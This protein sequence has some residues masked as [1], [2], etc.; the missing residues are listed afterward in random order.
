MKGMFEEADDVS[1][2][3]CLFI[4]I[5]LINIRNYFS[6]QHETETGHH[7]PMFSKASRRYN[8]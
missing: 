4:L 5:D 3:I 8:T 1:T 7:I 2:A 6:T